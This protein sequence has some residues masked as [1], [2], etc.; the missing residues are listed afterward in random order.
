MYS[1]QKAAGRTPFWLYF[2]SL[3]HF[4]LAK[5]PCLFFCQFCET[6]NR[7]AAGGCFPTPLYCQSTEQSGDLQRMP[8][9]VRHPIRP[10]LKN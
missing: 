5:D 3:F 6:V 2:S 10:F 7:A 4:L 8:L 1:A 9:V